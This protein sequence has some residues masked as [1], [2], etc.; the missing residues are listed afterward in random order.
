MERGKGPRRRMLPACVW[1]FP[2]T[3]PCSGLFQASPQN[4]ASRE[5]LSSSLGKNELFALSK[6]SVCLIRRIGKRSISGHTRPPAQGTTE[7]LPPHGQS[8]HP[9]QLDLTAVR[10]NAQNS[11]ANLHFG[12][13]HYQRPHNKSTG[14]HCP[15]YFA[16]SF[17]VSQNVPLK[18]WS[19][20]P[21]TN[22]MVVAS[23]PQA[24]ENQE[25]LL[26]TLLTPG[27]LRICGV[28]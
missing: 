24:T 14:K 23:C 5:T 27:W 3:S 22:G 21:T 20:K 7:T 10:Q 28:G 19:R 13:H 11:S 26:T 8:Q 18:F 1:G 9:L 6:E 15:D 12:H 2:L 17:C 16:S 4:G 25:G